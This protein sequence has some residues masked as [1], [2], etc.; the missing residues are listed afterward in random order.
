MSQLLLTFCALVELL[1]LLLRLGRP[2]SEGAKTKFLRHR[3]TNAE[4]EGDTDPSSSAVCEKQESISSVAA[5]MS[6]TKAVTGTT[7]MHYVYCLTM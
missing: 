7:N 1:L 5:T 6:T 4:R 2:L 3:R